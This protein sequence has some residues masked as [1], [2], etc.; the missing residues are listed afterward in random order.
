MLPLVQTG[1]AGMSTAVRARVPATGTGV[2]PL[3]NGARHVWCARSGR[4]LHAAAAV[5]S[6]LARVPLPH[7][8]VGL[9]AL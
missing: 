4:S 8:F 2:R 9:R 6:R 5:V 7:R 1:G 3:H